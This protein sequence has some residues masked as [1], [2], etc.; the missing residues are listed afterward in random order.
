MTQSDV[1]DNSSKVETTPEIGSTTE[2]TE[3]GTDSQS[4]AL[5]TYCYS[6]EAAFSSAAE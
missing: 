3:E 2:V 1:A 6:Q 5:G 4:M